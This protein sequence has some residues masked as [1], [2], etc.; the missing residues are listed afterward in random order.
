V[1]QKLERCHRTWNGGAELITPFQSLEFYQRLFG[2][3]PEV[4][5][6]NIFGAVKHR[7]TNAERSVHRRKLV[8]FCFLESLVNAGCPVKHEPF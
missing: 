5:F 6:L 1:S 4:L 8:C 7:F 3:V 2:T